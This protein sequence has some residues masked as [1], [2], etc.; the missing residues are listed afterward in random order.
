MAKKVTVGMMSSYV[1]LNPTPV[2]WLWSQT[3]NHFGGW[4]NI[5]LQATATNPEFMLMY[6][7]H[8][9]PETPQQ[10]WNPL[11][12]QR[13]MQRYEKNKA[14][15]EQKLRGVTP[16]RTM[17]LLREPP[18]PEVEPKHLIWYEQAK[19]YANYVS[20]PDDAAPTPAYMPAIWYISNPFD[21]LDKGPVPQKI[22]TLSWIT[23]GIDRSA[24]HMK[25]LEFLRMVHEAPME[26]DFYGK[27]LPA[28]TNAA[29]INN[30]WH[31]MAPYYYN[32][33]V[34]NYADNDWY[35]TEKMW[36]SLLCWCLP[37]YYGGSAVDKLLPPESF[38]RLPSMDEKG[39]A[40]IKEVTAS[41][42]A[43][44]EAKDAIAEARKIVLHK[45]NLVNWIAEY[46][47]QFN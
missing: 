38:L 2:D 44:Y 43:W 16:D 20:A 8:D 25:R 13:R 15:L 17:F 3:P 45:L 7:F 30:K 46:V 47:E 6:N 12:M 27:N 19:A 23:S 18:L 35:A 40:Y 1:G 39:I 4:K 36:D 5:E 34:E 21:E 9:F 32:L 29:P 37:I 42:D 28:W 10:H 33:T 24:N 41:P 14:N 22:K 26:C 31:G 11:R